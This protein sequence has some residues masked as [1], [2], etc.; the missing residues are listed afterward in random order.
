MAGSYS[1]ITPP[2]ADF[3]STATPAGRIARL[4]R[5]NPSVAGLPGYSPAPPLTETPAGLETKTPGLFIRHCRRQRE[6]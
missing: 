5:G 4:C 2:G 3:Q 1:A 6:R